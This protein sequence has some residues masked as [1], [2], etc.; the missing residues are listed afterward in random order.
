M[1][2]S[3]A[4]DDRILLVHADIPASDG[5][6]RNGPARLMLLLRARRRLDR[7]APHPTPL[8]QAG[9]GL[10]APAPRPFSRV[11]KKVAAKRPDEGRPPIPSDHKML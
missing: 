3:E 2:R 9:E 5:P 1:E 10:F 8:P 11:R 6:V 7:T 4:R